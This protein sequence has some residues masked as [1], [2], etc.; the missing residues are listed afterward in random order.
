MRRRAEYSGKRRSRKN[1]WILARKQLSVL[2]RRVF[3]QLGKKVVKLAQR[4]RRGMGEETACT[5]PQ[6]E[7]GL[8]GSSEGFS[9]DG[10]FMKC[11]GTGFGVL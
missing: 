11:Q 7:R 3:R 5:R 8:H 1:G 2:E 4:G 6:A 10:A 9:G